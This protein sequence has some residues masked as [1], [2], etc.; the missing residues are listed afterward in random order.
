MG[1]KIRRIVTGHNAQG[2]ATVMINDLAPNTTEIKGW[3]GLWVTELWTTNEMPV[4]NSASADQGARPIRHDPTPNGT[5]FRVVEFPPESK[6]LGI[7]SKAAFEHLGSHNKPTAEDSAKH[8]SMH[9]TDSIDYL[10]VIAGEM[11]MVMEE[12]EVLLRAGDC[13][14]QRGTNHAWVNKSDKPCLLA[15]ILIDA[16]PAP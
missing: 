10:M 15:A 6:T 1:Q 5:I 3:P 4:D 8:P 13:V 2:K 11:W 14:V 16:K 7:D 12:G 9:K